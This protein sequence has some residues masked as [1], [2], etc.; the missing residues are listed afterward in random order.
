VNG[1]EVAAFRDENGVVHAVDPKCTHMGC[2]VNWN[3]AEQTWDCP[4]HGSRFDMR[5]V[6]IEGPA[7]KDLERKTL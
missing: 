5:G 7:T 2:H 3:T 6:V 4:C 1:E